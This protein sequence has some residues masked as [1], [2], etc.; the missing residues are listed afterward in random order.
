MGLSQL[1]AASR[2]VRNI[3]NQPSRFKM[4]QQN[5][6][7]K[8][9]AAKPDVAG[10]ADETPSVVQVATEHV[11]VQS[12]VNEVTVVEQRETAKVEPAVSKAA[13]FAEAAKKLR[14]FGNWSLFK[15]PFRRAEPR[16][17]A[18]EPA[19]SEL[20]LDLV[21]PVR[22]DLSEVDFELA[23]TPCLATPPVETRREPIAVPVPS[24]AGSSSKGGLWRRLKTRLLGADDK[25]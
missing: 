18:P 22:N 12:V 19:Q 14:P 9:G 2:T 8:F 11:V 20:S 15:N 1:L 21:K 10:A 4:T 3:R 6:L 17:I 7:P 13:A 23:R 24:A 16:K 25:N 5:L